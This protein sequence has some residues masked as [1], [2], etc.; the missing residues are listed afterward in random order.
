MPRVPGDVNMGGYGQSP[1][2]SQ[3]SQANLLM[4]AAQVHQASLADPQP[5]MPHGPKGQPNPAKPAHKGKRLRIV[6]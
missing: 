2:T 5:T 3:P 1:L 4:A 6:K